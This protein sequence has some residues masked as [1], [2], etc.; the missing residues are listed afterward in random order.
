MRL[1]RLACAAALTLSLAPALAAQ[2]ASTFT[3]ALAERADVKQALGYIDAN[4]EAQV[5]EWIRLT[6]IPGLSTHE[7]QRAAYVMAELKKMSGL[8]VSTD[9][10]GN[11]TARRPGTGGGPAIVVASHMDTVRSA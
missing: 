1:I 7:Q 10:M 8:Q 5:A 3:P 6:E 9:P 11:I 4:F 2:S